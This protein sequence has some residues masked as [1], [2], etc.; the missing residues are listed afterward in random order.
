[1]KSKNLTKVIVLNFSFEV[2]HQMEKA[3]V[4]FTIR[5]TVCTALIAA[6]SKSIEIK[7]G[8]KAGQIAQI[9]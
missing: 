4:N 6:S 5:Y 9:M 7:R 3:S 1:M 8:E 2:L